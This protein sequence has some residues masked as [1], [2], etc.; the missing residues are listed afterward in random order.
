MTCRALMA[1]ASRLPDPDKGEYLSPVRMGRGLFYGFFM[2]AGRKN[3]PLYRKNLQVERMKLPRPF[4]IWMK[5][6]P[7]R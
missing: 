1:R 4:V 7:L 5:N 2:F 6:K 3:L